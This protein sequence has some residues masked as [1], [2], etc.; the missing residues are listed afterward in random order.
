MS[1]I[2][3]KEG[4][5]AFL[6]SK[7]EF[8]ECETRE[9]IFATDRYGKIQSGVMS[10]G[11]TG[12][13]CIILKVLP[14]SRVVITTISAY[15]STDANNNSAP[16]LAKRTYA[17]KQHLFRSFEG[18]VCSSPH[19]QPLRLMPGQSM[20]KPK[21]SWLL[22]DRVVNV[23]LSVIGTF[24]KPGW[25]VLLQMAPDS[26]A[27]LQAD[28]IKSTP[29]HNHKW[30]LRHNENKRP[31][32]HSDTA[33]K[34]PRTHLDTARVTTNTNK[35]STT[36]IKPDR[37]TCQ[38]GNPGGTATRPKQVPWAVV[39]RSEAARVT[40]TTNNPQTTII[41]VDRLN[42]HN[43]NLGWTAPQPNQISWAAITA[44]PVA[45]Q[46][47]AN[48]NNVPRRTTANINRQRMIQASA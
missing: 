18:S 9:L 29:R 15:G 38:V 30:L 46:P 12:H 35:P 10:A 14:N 3:W 2:T 43:H 20:P 39:V 37:L 6:K 5:I 34:R 36:I 13:P 32:A 44:R 17:P 7:T 27:H 8:T 28:I 1:S 16:W 42:S 40:T 19:Q 4:D 47:T 45:H 24:T 21:A 23:P 31:R 22:I 26:L 33:N 25:G 48:A 11:A 41:E